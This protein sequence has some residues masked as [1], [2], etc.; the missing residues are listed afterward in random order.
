[1]PTQTTID[2]VT[3]SANLR[4]LDVMQV[5]WPNPVQSN[6]LRT[7]QIS[8]NRTGDDT[9]TLEFSLKQLET[10]CRNL[11]SQHS[12]AAISIELIPL[13][14][15]DVSRCCAQKSTIVANVVQAAQLVLTFQA[16]S[17]DDSLVDRDEAVAFAELLVD[18]LHKRDFM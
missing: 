16:Q 6:S 14:E 12:Q 2:K 11:A 17:E 5:A 4:V 18:A 9:R 8:T 15:H 13:R 10:I 1:M 3:I 7:Q